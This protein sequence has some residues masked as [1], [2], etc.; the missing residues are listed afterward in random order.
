MDAS[1][2]PTHCLG[3]GAP[4][5]ESA[6]CEYCGAALP[7]AGSAQNVNTSLKREPEP[8][9]AAPF[10]SLDTEQSPHTHSS[11][12]S[13]GLEPVAIG[14]SE[15]LRAGKGV[16]NNLLASC[17]SGCAMALLALISCGLVS[18]LIMQNLPASDIPSWP[19]FA[20]LSLA[21]AFLVGLLAAV[22]ILIVKAVRHGFRLKR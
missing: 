20:L 11:Y 5:G 13:S 2:I 14:L 15:A 12:P 21:T 19:F 1:N 10:E 17:L 9:A 4:A 18:W 22:V 16:L 7:G 3:C 6:I 8:S